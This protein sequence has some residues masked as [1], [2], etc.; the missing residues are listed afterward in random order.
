MSLTQSSLSVQKTYQ[1]DRIYFFFKF[2]LTEY[3]QGIVPAYV[4]MNI[5][6]VLITSFLLMYK[7]IGIYGTLAGLNYSLFQ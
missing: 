7:E 6:V 3:F 1:T 2:H 5:H 4:L